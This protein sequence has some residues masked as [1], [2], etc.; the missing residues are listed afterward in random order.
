MPRNVILYTTH[1]PDYCPTKPSEHS[2]NTAQSLGKEFIAAYRWLYKLLGVERATWCYVKIDDFSISLGTEMDIYTLKVPSDKVTAI[3]SDIWNCAISDWP[4]YPEFYYDLSDDAYDKATK[5]WD[6]THDKEKSWTEH[7]F[8]SGHSMEYLIPN[9]LPPEWVKEVTRVSGWEKISDYESR[10]FY[11]TLS[12]QK[13]LEAAL[14]QSRGVKHYL[15]IEGGPGDD[16]ADG[17]KSAGIE[18]H[19]KLTQ[20]ALEGNPPTKDHPLLAHLPDSIKNYI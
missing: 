15:R 8:K 2:L 7:I 10:M 19:V 14:N 20:E 17:L 18:W 11:D 12:A 13:W 5:E 3:N 1:T 6:A 4:I 9:P 16:R